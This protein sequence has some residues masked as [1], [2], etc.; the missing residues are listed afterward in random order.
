MGGSG[1]PLPPQSPRKR[2]GE[3]SSPELPD[4]QGRVWD[5]LGLTV[6]E[7]GSTT[8]SICSDLRPGQFGT[9]FWSNQISFRAQAGPK[10]FRWRV[11]WRALEGLPG[12]PGPPRARVEKPK[13]ITF[14][15]ALL[16]GRVES[17][18][19]TALERV[20]GADFLARSAPFVERDPSGRVSGPNLS[21]NR[22]YIHEAINSYAR[23]RNYLI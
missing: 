2:V 7:H 11:K 1:G 9:G 15:R 6:N 22:P 18:S 23:V 14:C 10:P 16:S 8:G 19:T 20:Y 4:E 12:A 17:G 5:W 3:T 21:G 13:T